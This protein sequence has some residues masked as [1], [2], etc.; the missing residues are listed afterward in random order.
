MVVK[1]YFYLLQIFAVI[2]VYE[3]INIQRVLSKCRSQ[4]FWQDIS[5]IMN[6]WMS[7]QHAFST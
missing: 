4:F 2:E 5:D 7:F 3:F 6:I 1:L